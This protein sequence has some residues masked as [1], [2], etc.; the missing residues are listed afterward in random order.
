MGRI[1]TE[2]ELNQK[3]DFIEWENLCNNLCS[4]YYSTNRVD[5]SNGKGNGLDAYRITDNKFVE[6]FQFKKFKERLD[7]KQ[8]ET[9]RK[10]ITLAYDKCIEDFGKKL[11]R[12]IIICNINF[13]PSHSKFEGELSK[14]TKKIEKWALDEY[15]VVIEYFGLNWVHTR[16]LENPLLYPSLFEDVNEAVSQLRTLMKNKVDHLE[17]LMFNMLEQDNEDLTKDYSKI[18]IEQGYVHYKRA[19][20]TNY[21]Q[22]IQSAIISLN[23]AKNLVSHKSII[24]INDLKAKISMLLAG[25][26]TMTVQYTKAIDNADEAILL[27]ADE[28]LIMFAKGNKAYALF[29]SEMKL[30]IAESLF[31]EVLFYF[32]EKANLTEIIRTLTHLLELEIYK[33]N[34]NENVDIGTFLKLCQRLIST[35]MNVNEALGGLFDFTAA[36]IGAVANAF[37]YLGEINDDM[38]FYD[39]SLELLEFIEVEA[40]NSQLTYIFLSA[41]S[42]KAHLLSLLGD[43]KVTELEYVE[44]IYECR[45]AEFPQILANSLFNLGIF[46]AERE[47]WNEM[48]DALLEAEK[49][50]L[51]IGDGNTV[52]TIRNI[53]K[54]VFQ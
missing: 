46:E 17:T 23:D 32:E 53:I 35:C 52:E 14:F 43:D 13:D 25:L 6:G 30:D 36:G 21:F 40:E 4:L 28:E 3:L 41:K 1:T 44:L 26:Y 19:K 10:N 37:K 18:L 45:K 49:I 54:S 8:I 2:V 48:K 39:K 9:L 50:Y 12:Y 47:R 20:S 31:R 34:R 38:S 51:T 15:D 24:E 16:L 29:N 22:N 33:L 42:S 7:D 11:S 5:D 27:L